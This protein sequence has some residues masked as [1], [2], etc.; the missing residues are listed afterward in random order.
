[1]HGLGL[2]TLLTPALEGRTGWAPPYFAVH[3]PDGL[4]QQIAY[5]GD[6]VCSPG[7]DLAGEGT[8]VF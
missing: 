5:F 7:G 6:A 8:S 3:F 2:R 4:A 1:M